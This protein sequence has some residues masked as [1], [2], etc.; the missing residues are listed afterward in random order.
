MGCRQSDERIVLK[1]EGNDSRGKA[2]T[3][4]HIK[5]TPEGN[6]MKSTSASTMISHGF[7]N[8]GICIHG[9]KHASHSLRHSLAT[10]MLADGEDILPI[11]KTIGHSSVESTQIY[12]RSTS[13]TYA[14]VIWRCMLMRDKEYYYRKDMLLSSLAMTGVPLLNTK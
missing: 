2:V 3:Q 12:H 1:K 10:N 7:V 11:S 9:R 4:S 5:S 8:S 6:A 14:S 13:D